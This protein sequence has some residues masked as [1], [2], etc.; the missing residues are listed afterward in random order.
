MIKL[1]TNAECPNHIEFDGLAVFPLNRLNDI[2][3][4][5]RDLCGWEAIDTVD[6]HVK[7]G[8]GCPRKNRARHI[9]MTIGECDGKYRFRRTMLVEDAFYNKRTKTLT[10]YG[11]EN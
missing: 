6:V 4:A 10:V 8:I 7:D 2:T 9:R 11:Y 1:V 3:L 5:V